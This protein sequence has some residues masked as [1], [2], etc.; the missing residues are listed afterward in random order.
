MQVE[1]ELRALGKLG[2]LTFVSATTSCVV[3]PYEGGIDVFL[4]RPRLVAPVKEL[5]RAWLPT[6]PHGL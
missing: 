6:N 5:F 1:L 4:P 2:P 3:C